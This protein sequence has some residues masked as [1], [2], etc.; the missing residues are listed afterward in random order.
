M[1]FIPNPVIHVFNEVNLGKYK[2]TKHYELSQCINGKTLLSSKLN[3]SKDR[4]FAK[5]MPDYWA[6]IKP[7]NKWSKNITGLF[8][9]D[10]PM[11]YHGDYDYKKHLLLFH[12][13][14]KAEIVVV[15]FYVNYFSHDLS[16]VLKKIG[17]MGRNKKRRCITAFN[18]SKC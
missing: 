15:Y 17:A 1:D 12:F 6:K 18:C 3:I 9:T 11:I 10:V 16:H 14:D 13:T 5:S 4:K 8:K 2:T 7:R